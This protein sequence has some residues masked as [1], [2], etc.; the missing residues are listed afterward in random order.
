MSYF[1]HGGKHHLK[2][3]DE[4][5]L[6][7]KFEIRSTCLRVA[8]PA[9]AGEIRK[10]FNGYQK[11]RRS[12]SGY[13]D[14]RTSGLRGLSLLLFLMS[15]FSDILHP[16]FLVSR[17]PIEICFDIRNSDFGFTSHYRSPECS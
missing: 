9:K 14:I 8:A 17:F 2:Y 3:C 13:Q 16:D 10:R 7:S 15:L 12:G 1:H 11:I 5:N 6:T 4:S